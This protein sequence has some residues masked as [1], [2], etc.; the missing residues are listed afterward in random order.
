MNKERENQ[1]STN[2]LPFVFKQVIFHNF[3]S[4]YDMFLKEGLNFRVNYMPSKITIR[5]NCIPNLDNK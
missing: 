4:K 3:I 1:K 2:P 5:A